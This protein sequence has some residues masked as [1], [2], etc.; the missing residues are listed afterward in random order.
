MESREHSSAQGGSQTYDHNPFLSTSETDLARA[1][2][3]LR[4]G[5]LVAFPTETVYG[6]GANAWSADATRRI[7]A[8]KGRPPTDPLI[9]HIT[10]LTLVKEL[11]DLDEHTHA[12]AMEI[13]QKFWPGPLTIV[14]KVSK[15]V[16]ETVT[17]GSGCVGIRVPE[18]PIARRLIEVSGVPIAAPS[19]NRFAHVSPTAAHHVASDLAARDP[20]LLIVDGGSC[21]IG[22]ESTVV[23]LTSTKPAPA[24]SQ[25]NAGDET[26]CVTVV[27]ILRRG[28]VCP[29]EI[30]KLL[31]I[32]DVNR[33]GRIEVRIRDTRSQVGA[34]A[35]TSTTPLDGPGQYVTHYSPEGLAAFLVEP[36]SF[37]ALLSQPHNDEKANTSASTEQCGNQVRSNSSNSKNKTIQLMFQGNPVALL[38]ECVIIDFGNL[39]R[40]ALT[41]A[42]MSTV[43]VDEMVVAYKS[44]SET[45]SAREACHE[46][47]DA[48]RW[49]EQFNGTNTATS[50]SEEHAAENNNSTAAAAKAV[51][52][53]LLTSW[54]SERW[55]SP[56][57]SRT[58]RA[59]AQFPSSSTSVSPACTYDKSDSDFELVQAVED[60]LFRAA[61]GQ[62]ATLERNTKHYS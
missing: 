54:H 1:G 51:I 14:A 9:V 60:R 39:I 15:N 27:E 21:T 36:E 41:D 22:I 31:E 29:M 34:V 58:E 26:H 55:V 24:S 49:C 45:A 50:S 30:K 5:N 59:P 17:G 57:H 61:S 37:A 12:L 6:L 43:S 47:F 25:N 16:P 7:F 62:V 42:E 33:T 23:K 19:A 10:D 32:N 44:L 4:N 28:N 46:V 11:W 8:V 13:G 53:P 20:S 35:V 52:F 2:E 56:P 40:N 38:S 48:L 3:H 18:H